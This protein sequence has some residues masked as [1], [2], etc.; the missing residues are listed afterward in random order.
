MKIPVGI[1][2]KMAFEIIANRLLNDLVSVENI[3]DKETNPHGTFELGH[4]ETKCR[5]TVSVFREERKIGINFS[6]RH[7][8]EE[9]KKI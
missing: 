6:D 8:V 1:S 5:V 3:F 7:K 9:F 4:S 2:S